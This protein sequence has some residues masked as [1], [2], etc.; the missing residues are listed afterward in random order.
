MG[1]AVSSSYFFS[2]A[3]S[4][5]GGGLLTLF[6]CY[7]RETVLQGPLHCQSFSFPWA[8]VLHELLQCGSPMESQ[9]LAANL[10]QQELLSPRVHRSCQESAPVWSSHGVTASFGCIHL[11]ECGILHALQVDI[12][13]DPSQIRLAWS[14]VGSSLDL[15][16]LFQCVH[17]FADDRTV[18]GSAICLE[19]L[20]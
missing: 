15:S 9:V 6:P 11:F 10:L 3:P 1:V 4:S 14:S 13:I 8:T 17:W 19:G 5:S 2:A 12:I 7:T 16:F 18:W 20:C